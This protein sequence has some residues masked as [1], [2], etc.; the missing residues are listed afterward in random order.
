MSFVKTPENIKKSMRVY[1]VTDR[2]FLKE[3]ETL[4]DQVR[5]SLEGGAT[6]MQIREKNITFDEYVALSK[7]LMAISHEYGVPFVVNDDVDV[8]VAIG[9]DGAHV[10]QS[11][12]ESGEAR[13]KLGPNAILGVSAATVEEAL[14]AIKNG[15]DYLGV[16]AV[17]STGTK[18]DADHV[19]YDTLKEI[20]RVSTVPIVAIGGISHKNVMELKGSGIDGV[21]VVSAIFGAE[22]I[23]KSTRELYDLV[24]EVI[25]K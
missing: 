20:C 12:L 14:E 3:G 21:A 5:K 17:F 25:E 4:A 23:V 19:D 13:R 6:F 15:A 24:G 18:L 11:D 2:M 16:G 7:E 22:D 8:A 9:A 10:G 1:A